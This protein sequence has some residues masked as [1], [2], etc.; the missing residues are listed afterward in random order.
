MEFQP[1]SP[2][3]SASGL[4]RGRPK[5]GAG[6]P[7][8]GD[9]PAINLQQVGPCGAKRASLVPWGGGHGGFLGLVALASSTSFFGHGLLI[10]L[11]THP[12]A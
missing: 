12:D 4:P 10:L 1:S 11:C 5:S 8:R 7:H 9:A 6:S 2:K 3:I